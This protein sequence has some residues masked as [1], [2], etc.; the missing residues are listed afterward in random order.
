M[1]KFFKFLT[2]STL[3]LSMLFSIACKDGGDDSGGGDANVDEA[4]VYSMDRLK[5]A[6]LSFEFTNKANNG[7]N[8]ASLTTTA[9]ND[10]SEETYTGTP[11][12]FIDE[13]Q[14]TYF[15]GY[16]SIAKSIA[17]TAKIQVEELTKTVTVLNK[18]VIFNGVMAR[19]V[20]YDEENDVVTAF[21]GDIND[22]LK[23]DAEDGVVGDGSIIGSTGENPNK[24]LPKGTLT[25]GTIIKIYD[26]ADGDEVVEYSNFGYTAK[27]M[28]DETKGS[29]HCVK[30]KYVPLKEYYYSSQTYETLPASLDIIEGKGTYH[31]FKALNVDG[32]FI[33]GETSGQFENPHVETELFYEMN[34]GFYVF[35][36]TRNL[37]AF[38]KGYDYIDFFFNLEETF[39]YTLPLKAVG[40]W[41]SF[42]HN[43]Q[44]KNDDGIINSTDKD[45]TLQQPVYFSEGD[46]ILLDNG[47]KIYENSVWSKE[48]GFVRIS[49]DKD[50]AT[51]EDGTVISITDFT[52][53]AH[54]A[55]YGFI[56]ISGIYV[57]PHYTLDNL[58]TGQIYGGGIPMSLMSFPS[59]ETPDGYIEY[60]FKQNF[61]SIFKDFVVDN[62]LKF[63]DTDP[64]EI[65]DYTLTASYIK[66]TMVDQEFQLLFNRP[67]TEEGLANTVNDFIA[68]GKGIIEEARYCFNNYE[69]MLRKDMPA[70]NDDYSLI[71]TT[72]QGSVNVSNG[73]FDF[74][75]VSISIPKT[76][77][78]RKGTNYG[79][80]VYLEGND[81][82]VL[83][84]AFN[85]YT[86]NKESKT[87]S[88]NSSIAIP[89]V[90]DGNYKLKLAFGKPT[91]DGFIRLSNVIELN[92]NNFSK[93]NT[94]ST[95]DGKSYNISYEC[96]NGKFN[97]QSSYNDVGMPEIQNCQIVG[98]TVEIDVK[99]GA[100]I[101]DFIT[102]IIV[103]DEVDGRIYLNVKDFT[104]DGQSVKIND[105]I[106]FTKTYLLT[107]KD[108]SGNTL[109]VN[110]KPNIRVEK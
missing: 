64:L 49:W 20:G 23:Q 39:D 36:L 19:Y 28:L 103:V 16:T 80:M 69:R 98:D 50:T 53:L 37:G 85:T 107:I 9:F 27:E 94:Q 87:L 38:T 56:I 89:S 10:D 22:D 96:V 3:S 1:K 8:L 13:G 108:S 105:A 34:G 99:E 82:K 31:V 59:V 88:G 97:L 25:H 66:D 18:L 45:I 4:Y 11:N 17:E 70:V 26:D 35:D 2:A 51:Y 61:F 75:N 41:N 90:K 86:Y 100:I 57:Q 7:I 62:E 58:R 40:G 73:K 29:Y 5:N 30:I 67:Y 91:E 65:I 102:D 77:F 71:S 47:K 79:V 46:Y 106:D 101:A 110:V 68:L 24:V 93:V 15:E 81:S 78:L 14:L 95:I 109:Q 55:D 84:G 52:K 43:V 6:D 92:V 104:L 60:E 33:G 12:Y 32:K 21:I 42:Y 54:E 63:I 72:A 44:D 76:N 48:T 74:S 83:E